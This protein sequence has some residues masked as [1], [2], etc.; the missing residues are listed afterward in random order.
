MPYRLHDPWPL[1]RA[2]LLLSV[3]GLLE[4]VRRPRVRPARMVL[5]LGAAAL[6]AWALAWHAGIQNVYW[7][8]VATMG[9]TLGGGAALAA[10]DRRWRRRGYALVL[11]AITLVGLF[12]TVP[13]TGDAVVLLGVALPV[14]A[15]GWPWVVA[16]LG[17]GGSFAIAGLL[18]WVAAR[19]GYGRQSA[20]IGGIAC[21]GLLAVEPLIRGFRRRAWSPLELVPRGWRFVPLVA[22]VHLAFVYVAS[23]VAGLEA[24]APL[25]PGGPIARGAVAGSITIVLIELGAALLV[26]AA[27]RTRA[28]HK[29]WMQRTRYSRSRQSLRSENH[30]G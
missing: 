21:L 24:T 8:R 29:G 22:G 9:A 30:Y 5:A 27:L 18:A 19:G 15:L 7:V 10:F 23:R 28:A 14:A 16:R 20:I 25:R 3:G 2:L 13:D 1:L 11:L 6:G 12:Y 17:A 4:D 26:A